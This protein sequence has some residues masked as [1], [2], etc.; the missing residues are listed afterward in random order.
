MIY[1][2]KY[3]VELEDIGISN[4]ISNKRII[5]IMED[6]AASHS[7]SLGYGLKEVENTN[8]AW[9]LLD[10]KIKILGRPEYNECIEA[11]TWARKSDKLCAYRDFELKDNEGKIFAIGSSRWLYMNL[12]KRRPVVLDDKIKNIY[13]IEQGK[14]VFNEEICK[15]NI[16]TDKENDIDNKEN[17]IEIIERPYRTERRDM[18]INGHMHNVSYIEAAYEILPEDI[19]KNIEYSNIRVEYKKEIME[20]DEVKIKCIIFRNKKCL[21]TFSSENKLHA[22]I[23]LSN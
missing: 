23:E 1:R 7:D 20:N 6:I 4:R 10:W 9:V 3:K 15:I 21:I 16:M 18:D 5:T 8:C 22:V 12:L 2:E 17:I 19:Y 13:E 14:M 11:S